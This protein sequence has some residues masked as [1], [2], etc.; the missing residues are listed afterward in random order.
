MVLEINNKPIREQVFIKIRFMI[1]NYELKPGDKIYES[2]ISREL[3]V[4]RTPVREA[5]HRLEEEG[6]LTIY[7]R[8]YCLVNGITIDSIHEINLIRANL[9]PLTA[10]IAAEKLTEEELNNLEDI[11]DMSKKAYDNDDIETMV[12]L[13]DDF[14]NII[15][16]SAKLPRITKLLENLQDYY[17]I[18]RYS[19]MR[20]KNLALRTL[21]EHSDIIEALKTRDKEY[22]EE[23]YKR[24][25]N[26]ILEYEYV[27]VNEDITNIDILN[28]EDS[29]GRNGEKYS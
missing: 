15:I 27:A 13:N 11:L 10:K 28:K 25:V 5:F 16:H 1:L 14:H 22:V 24:H 17:M 26:G 7:P 9:E 20:K 23:V 3:G 2:E 8:R 18:F 21:E 12:N 29:H 6:L 4:S 19:Y